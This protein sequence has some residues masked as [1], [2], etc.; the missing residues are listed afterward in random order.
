MLR[1][2][3][4]VGA[5]AIVWRVRGSKPKTAQKTGDAS[6]GGD[7]PWLQAWVRALLT[8]K[9]AAPA[10]KFARIAWTLM[11]SGERDRMPAL[12]AAG[13]QPATA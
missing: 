12:P 2:L 4:V 11:Q 5:T 6:V 8:R 7:E 1:S 13:P 10:N 9:L 3:L